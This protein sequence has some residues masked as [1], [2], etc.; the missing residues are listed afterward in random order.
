MASSIRRQLLDYEA[1][2]QREHKR[3][4][5]ETEAAKLGDV[6]RDSSEVATDHEMQDRPVERVFFITVGCCCVD[7]ITSPGR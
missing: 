1:L 7:A 2:L 3:K 6:K 5:A 4:A